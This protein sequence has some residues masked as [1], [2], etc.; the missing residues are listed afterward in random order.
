MG[1]PAR[2]SSSARRHRPASTAAAGATAAGTQGCERGRVPPS[3]L[4]VVLVIALVTPPLVVAD[5]RERRLP[6]PLVAAAALGLGASCAAVLASGTDGA[7]ASVGRAALAVLGG[8]GALL[9][10]ALAGGV[11]MG[12]VKLGGVLAGAAALL[13]PVGVPLGALVAGLAGGI[14]A[15]VVAVGRGHDPGLR[16]ERPASV[17]YGPALLLGW[18][19]V[20]LA[21]TA[22]GATTLFGTVAPP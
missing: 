16:P 3:L 9:V 21:E 13:D 4:P 22:G 7:A 10:L 6:N 11:G 17:P 14:G 20:P 1:P 5:L 15:V 18:W 19:S 2:R 12:D 8:G